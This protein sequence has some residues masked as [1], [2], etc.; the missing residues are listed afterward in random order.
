MFRLLPAITTRN[1]YVS[2]LI[3][4]SP[5]S[6]MLRI[7]SA[8]LIM[9]VYI[10]SSELTSLFLLACSIRRAVSTVPGYDPRPPVRREYLTLVS[11]YAPLT[12]ETISLT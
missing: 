11:C 2:L 3:N 5:L 12:L 7:V 10:A 1:V 6:H 4:V 8:I 9:C